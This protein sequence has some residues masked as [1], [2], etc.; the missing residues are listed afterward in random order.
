MIMLA[1]L[2]DRA[3]LG[4]Q[5]HLCATKQGNVFAGIP[6]SNDRVPDL[7]RLAEMHGLRA[8]DNRSFFRGTQ[9]IGLEFYGRKAG[10]AGR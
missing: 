7:G 10:R 6:V 4:V 9:M 8:A 1:P 5:N 2:F 3:L